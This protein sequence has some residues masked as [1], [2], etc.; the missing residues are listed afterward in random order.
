MGIEKTIIE[1]TLHGYS[2]GHRLLS[3]SKKFSDNEI[4]KMTILSDLSGN[5]FVNGFEK[6]YTGYRLNSDT[7]VLACTWYATEM[8]RP[9]CVWTHSLIF[10]ENDLRKYGGEMGAVF[11][12]FRKPKNNNDF[13]YYNKSLEIDSESKFDFDKQKLKYL[14]WCLWGNRSPLVVFSNCASEYENEI[15]YLFLTQHDILE[16][17]FSFCTGSVSLRSIEQT[18]MN[19]QIAPDK[20][21]RS[22]FQIGNGV[23]EAK[24]ERIIKSYPMWVNK[25]SEYLVLDNIK[26][27]KKFVSGFSNTYKRSNYFSA[28]MK[29]YVGSRAESKKLSLDSLLQ[30][31]SAIFNEKKNICKEIVDLYFQ[32]YFSYWTGEGNYVNTLKFFIDNLWL[33]VN[34]KNIEKM[35][36]GGIESEY[37]QIKLLFNNIVGSEENCVIE[38]ILEVLAHNINLS[39]FED[40]TNMKYECCSIMIT[41]NS[42]YAQ[43]HGLWNQ[44]KGF[45]QGIIRC[46]DP[47]QGDETL[48]KQIISTVLAVSDF[49]LAYDLYRVYGEVC[50]NVFW[51]YA[52]LNLNGKSIRGIKQI[53]GKDTSK[54]IAMIK[55]NLKDR[56]C[57]LFLIDITNSYNYSIKNITENELKQLFKTLKP[58]LCNKKEQ[59][60]LARFLIPICLIDDF[61][62][63]TEIVRFAY[64]QVNRLLA[65][66]SFPEYEWEKLEELLPE[67]AWYNNWDRCKRLRKGLKKK[68]YQIKEL[69]EK[70]ELPKYLL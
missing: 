4:K 55:D 38:E 27:F 54:C 35:V 61:M 70:E 10:S 18:I 21:S 1:Q 49:D 24:E 56:E 42:E 23:V 33:D 67:V 29:L 16:E 28:F 25:A 8:K 11:S 14:I 2:N 22:G 69:K 15:V 5:E 3:F 48:K 19:F 66:Q 65:T 64:L 47:K 63:D 46:L 20:L 45:Q 51:N 43:C 9:G 57:L 37:E 7:I 60:S 40:F 36:M 39:L 30:M 17:N 41:L 26:D 62:V 6:Y 68:G 31:A 52:M 32:N 59:E 34:R 12:L 44:N 58:E 50:I 53:I 13:S